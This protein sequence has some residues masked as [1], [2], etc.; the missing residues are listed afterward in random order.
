MILCHFTQL[1]TRKI[2]KFPHCVSR[3]L[4]ACDDQWHPWRSWLLSI[5]H[6]P[7][8]IFIINVTMWI[9]MAGQKLLNLENKINLCQE[10][11]SLSKY[12]SSRA[13]HCHKMHGNKWYLKYIKI[14]D[15]AFHCLSNSHEVSATIYEKC[16]TWNMLFLIIIDHK[17][18]N[19]S[20]KSSQQ[21][22]AKMF[23]HKISNFFLDFSAA[24]KYIS[25]LITHLFTITFY[26]TYLKTHLDNLQR[27]AIC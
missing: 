4:V 7:D 9:L 11:R 24:F 19:F 3:T 10:K 15:Q 8:K 14:S 13:Y 25:F 1:I 2:L 12:G 21:S 5:H 20:E 6:S 26:W 22:I 16:R 27:S 18:E 17:F 23:S